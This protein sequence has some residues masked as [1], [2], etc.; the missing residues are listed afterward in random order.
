MNKDFFVDEFERQ[1]DAR[2]RLI[3]PAKVREQLGDMIYIT[4]SMSDKCLHLYSEKEWEKLGEKIS[5]LPTASDRNAAAFVRLFYGKA[6]ACIVDK[7]GRVVISKRLL[8]YA[9]IE[10]DAVLVG[11]NTRLELWAQD[12]WDEYQ[13]SLSDDIMLEGVKKYGLNI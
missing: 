9:G 6:T 5:E 4:R 7:Q 12:E 13:L 8:E 10:K 11:V 2:G 1:I 3:L